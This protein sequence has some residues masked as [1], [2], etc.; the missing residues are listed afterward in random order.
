MISVIKHTA[1]VLFAAI[2]MIAS[3]GFNLV[4]HYCACTGMEFRAVMVQDVDCEHEK[5]S[6]CCNTEKVRSPA[7]DHCETNF[8]AEQDHQDH[9]C[10]NTE[11]TFFKTDYFD[12]QKSVKKNFEFV[13][14]YV[15]VIG[16]DEFE[17]NEILQKTGLTGE[18]SPPELFGKE[19]LT[20][21][22][23]LK[24]AASPLV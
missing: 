18:E 4:H 15:V 16:T 19:L 8:P 1:I 6:H 20:S 23:Q 10:C 13:A 14:A 11:F 24:I 17:D 5:E 7:C 3:G 12:I 21:I 2:V 9:N 22:Q